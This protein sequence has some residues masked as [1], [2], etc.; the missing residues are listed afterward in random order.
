MC[1][2]ADC[3]TYRCTRAFILSFKD[4]LQVDAGVMG[5]GKT[6]VQLTHETSSAHAH[7]Q[8]HSSYRLLEVVPL[9]QGECVGLGDDGDDVDHLAEA[10]H[11]LHIQRPQT[12]GRHTKM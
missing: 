10:P 8:T 7:P 1:L 9:L 4:V 12:A 2:W 11:E 3:L 5:G 6:Y